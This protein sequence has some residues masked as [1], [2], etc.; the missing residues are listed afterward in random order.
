[1]SYY[2]YDENDIAKSLKK[3]M[4]QG[5]SYD[6]V[7]HLLT[8]RNRK[9]DAGGEGMAQYK[10][11]DLTQDA[12]AY[13][14]NKAAKP[15]LD[16]S[17][18]QAAREQV[19]AQNLRDANNQHRS[20]YQGSVQRIEEDARKAEKAAAADYRKSELA[21]SERL[22]TL[23]LGR[24]KG[25]PTSGYGESMRTAAM[26][27]YQNNLDAVRSAENEKKADAYAQYTKNLHESRQSYNA[28]RDQIAK[29]SAD[30]AVKQFN[31]DREYTLEEGK[32]N[33]A[34]NQWN[35]AFDAGQTE[36]KAQSSFDNAMALFEK[37]GEV[38]T[39][40]MARA[41]GLPVGTRA[42]SFT[43]MLQTFKETGE[44]TT[45]EMS[46]VLGLPIGTKTSARIAFEAQ[47]A[48]D[49]AELEQSQQW[50]EDDE[51]Y[52]QQVLA[53]KKTTTGRSSSSAADKNFNNMFNLFKA[54]G[55]VT[56]E[57][58]SDVL[59]LPVGTQYWEYTQKQQRLEFEL[60][61]F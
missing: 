60:G 46:D 49:W 54:V 24:G 25:A 28:E 3:A 13:L 47:D 15:K 50:H 26:L 53:Q 27:H 6:E 41:L 17:S 14:A 55:E 7:K 29:D 32:H 51:N 19:A 10:N 48:L 1:M 37:T 35:Q 20:V 36:K 45:K 39:E 44:V 59:G 43:L 23:G 40:E 38:S 42:D 31:A 16:V 30:T 8:A 58:M 18:L 57:E 2:A 34:A 11:D 33:T 9:I 5:A 4:A 61:T 52:R 21:D 12:E 22:A 56:T